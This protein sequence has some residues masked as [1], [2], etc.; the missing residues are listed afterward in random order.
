MKCDDRSCKT[1]ERQENDKEYASAVGSA[2]FGPN[3]S[4]IKSTK[5]AHSEK[6]SN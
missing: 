5:G 6:V 4:E 2:Y 3:G 1:Q